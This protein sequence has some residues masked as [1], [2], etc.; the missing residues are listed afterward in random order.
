MDKITANTLFHFTSKDALLGILKTGFRPNY[1]TETGKSLSNDA[2]ELLVPMVCFCDLPISKVDRHIN[3][4]TWEYKGQVKPSKKYGEYGLGMT[5]EWGKRKRLNPVTY[6]TQ[7][8]YMLEFLY[9]M[10]RN[11]RYLCT[12][13]QKIWDESSVDSHIKNYWNNP[14]ARAMSIGMPPLPVEYETLISAARA[15]SNSA[16]LAGYVKPYMD[17]TTGQLYYDEREWRCSVPYTRGYDGT[18]PIFFKKDDKIIPTGQHEFYEADMKYLEKCKQ[19]IIDRYMLDFSASD[20]KYLIL[21]DDSE[22]HEVVES[23]RSVPEKY[24]EKSIERL[25]T[26]IITCQQIKED[27]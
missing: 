27:F 9:E 14:I 19:N 21:K 18:V 3:G 20:I 26:R 10:D 1:S 16:A 11:L 22:I 23:L 13:L 25:M 7:E 15:L 5:K 2:P 17:F 4:Y 24:D 8:S 12:Q 6:I